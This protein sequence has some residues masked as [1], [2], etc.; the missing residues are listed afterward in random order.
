MRRYRGVQFAATM[1]ATVA[2]GAMAVSASAQQQ[3]ETPRYTLPAPTGV[4]P[5]FGLPTFGTPGAEM[6]RRQATAPESGTPDTGM[7]ATETL[8]TDTASTPSVP[9]FFKRNPGE[10]DFPDLTLP[11]DRAKTSV[12]DAASNSSEALPS[13]IRDTPLYTTS[14][15]LTTDETTPSSTTK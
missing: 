1:A 8:E 2:T 9:D 15:G 6:P 12:Q 10:N 4:D 5:N 3:Y 13:T 11:S 14:D 7:R